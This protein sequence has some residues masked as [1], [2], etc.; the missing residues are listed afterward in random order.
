MFYWITLLS[1]FILILT[2]S[3]LLGWLDLSQFF[4]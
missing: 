2:G 4:R 1:H 3:V